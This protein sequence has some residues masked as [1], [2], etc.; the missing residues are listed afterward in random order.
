[1]NCTSTDPTLG[2]NKLLALIADRLNCLTAY[3]NANV[4]Y[5]IIHDGAGLVFAAGTIRSIQ[6]TV[7][8]EGSGGST[9]NGKVLRTGQSISINTNGFGRIQTDINI[10]IAAGTGGEIAVTTVAAAS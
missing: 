8:N 4:Q 7:I 1:M 5:D 6:I 9:F 2:Q 3:E 10:A